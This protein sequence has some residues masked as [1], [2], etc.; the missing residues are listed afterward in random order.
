MRK[1]T[2]LTLILFSL[3][4]TNLI[5]QNVLS[6]TDS[7]SWG[8]GNS[9]SGKIT[10]ASISISPQGIYTA[11]G[12]TLTVG[13]HNYSFESDDLEIILDFT[14]PDGSIINDSW[15]WMLDQTTIVQ[16][17]V[18]ELQSAT[19]TYEDI[20]D[21]QTDPSLLYRKSNNNYRMKVFPLSTGQT[22]KFR[23]A[24]LVPNIWSEDEIKSFIPTEILNT[25][26]IEIPEIIIW[27]RESEQ[28]KNPQLI[29]P[30]VAPFEL[31]L[32]EDHGE[33]LLTSISH[34]D[35][36]KPLS[37]T[38]EAP[39]S[40]DGIYASNLIDGDDQFYQLA[41]IP[42]TILDEQ[43]S[44]NILFLNGHDPHNTNISQKGIMDYLKEVYPKHM[45]EGDKLNFI[46]ENDSGGEF[47]SDTW[48]TPTDF[49]AN[50]F[51]EDS[52]KLQ[53]SQGNVTAQLV[54]AL[55]FVRANGEAAEIILLTSEDW[56]DF[57]I[58]TPLKNDY[59]DLFSSNKVRITIL[60]YQS[61]NYNMT[62][63]GWVF[64]QATQLAWTTN[65]YNLYQTLSD[66]TTGKFY[67]G[68]NGQGNI[69]A[70]IDD[71]FRSL[72]SSDYLFDLHTSVSS[73]LAYGDFMQTYM[74]Q[75]KLPNVPILQTGRYLGQG[76]YQS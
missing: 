28:W 72:R 12:L 14:L 6:V 24:F 65:H 42:P 70:N 10:E 59:S 8:F 9:H 56:L 4:L 69:W 30:E 29:G 3:A 5:A 27:T 17:D 46:S 20:V 7:D 15:L 67:S 53:L 66:F 19:Q 1:I 32:L 64:G 51:F 33:V 44:K 61:K 55:E 57:Q 47:L 73:G 22:R 18:L 49:L 36:N 75:S 68:L 48:M 60:N 62:N 31:H 25:S 13:D 54:D 71:T 23:I 50:T 35:L 37:F 40:E 2:T 21:R 26:A 52:A 38:I 16:A 63:E 45:R 76:E 41:Y 34:S 39:F 74:G 43:D 58:L 11:V